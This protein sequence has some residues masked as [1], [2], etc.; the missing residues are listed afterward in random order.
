[1]E[2]G[3][4][5]EG[6]VVILP[7]L[8]LDPSQAN[9]I[10]ARK[11]LVSGQVKLSGQSIALYASE[12]QFADGSGID[13]SGGEPSNRW[14]AGD[15]APDGVL[16]G[17]AGA[18]GTDGSPGAN[19]GAIR[20]VAERIIGPIRLNTAGGAGGR[21]RDG[22]NGHDG[23]D[24]NPAPQRSKLNDNPGQPGERGG[25]GGRAGGSGNGGAGGDV[26]IRVTDRPSL[27]HVNA[28]FVGQSDRGP[29]VS[30]PSFEVRRP[31]PHPIVPIVLLDLPSGFPGVNSLQ[32]SGGA[33]GG[34]AHGG[35]HG[36]GGRGGAGGLHHHVVLRGAGPDKEHVIINDGVTRP[37]PDGANGEDGADGSAGEAGSPGS[38]HV[39][40]VGVDELAR[41]C[42]ASHLQML[43][44]SGEAL[45]RNAQFAAAAETLGYVLR[46][47]TAASAAR[48]H[49]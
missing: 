3:R 4:L 2:V 41:T 45:Y 5:I 31:G 32:T 8:G 6:D 44:R 30:D 34:R 21:G 35:K 28:E 24:G 14:S 20:I 47:A 40:L 26:D 10:R 33:G 48:R 27:D 36:K 22:G 25:N 15:R 19:G 46:V 12:V 9:I 42:T 18:D 37:A 49:P 17:Q 16:P 23:R 38:V 1:M 29:V 43:L 13:T 11:I 7:D 39:Q